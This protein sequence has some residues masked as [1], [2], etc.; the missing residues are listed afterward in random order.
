[1]ATHFHLK[2]TQI[3]NFI[4]NPKIPEKENSKY[5]TQINETEHRK[6]IERTKKTKT[7]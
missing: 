1:M 4:F 3:K 6:T 5:S 2:S 7:H